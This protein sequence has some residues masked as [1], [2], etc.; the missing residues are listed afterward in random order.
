MVVEVREMEEEGLVGEKEEE[1]RGPGSARAALAGTRRRRGATRRRWRGASA[2]TI[3][4]FDRT[5]PGRGPRRAQRL[6]LATSW[7]N[8]ESVLAVARQLSPEL[9]ARAE[10]AR[11]ARRLE[12]VTRP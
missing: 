12:E 8:D 7:R 3:E 5:F 11:S 1:M 9:A 2:G 4:R 10:T 6:T